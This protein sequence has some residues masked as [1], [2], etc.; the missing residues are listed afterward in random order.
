MSLVLSTVIIKLP[1][2]SL[3]MIPYMTDRNTLDFDIILFATKSK[4]T[5][6]VW[7]GFLQKNSKLIS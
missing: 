1:F 5:A 2:G 4:R 7:C 3:K 6:S